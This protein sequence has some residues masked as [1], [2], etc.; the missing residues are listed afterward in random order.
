[1][2]RL[3]VLSG[4]SGVGKG[5]MVDWMKKIYFTAGCNDQNNLQFCQVKVRKTATA[6]HT[7][8]ESELGL[9]SVS[10]NRYEF[11]CRG[12]QQAID[13]DELDKALGSHDTVLIEAYYV[14]FD[15]LKDRYAGSVDFAST[16]VSPLPP[17][18]NRS[19]L[20]PLDNR[21]VIP[22]I[23]LDSLI[24]RAL[25]E[26]KN[27]TQE[28]VGDLLVRAR[29]SVAELDVAHKYRNLMVNECYE[30]DSRWHFSTLSGEPLKSV[31][32]LYNIVCTG[33]KDV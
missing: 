6:R 10:K 18:D 28:L 15:A 3:V 33:S 16:F 32:T 24:R 17:P 11:D 13:F 5:P 25:R 8:N 7:G 26:S 4:P 9:E 1:M 27:M 20:P 30:A 29:G 21:L 14:A 23:M 2:K 22:D 31:K 19:P 12:S